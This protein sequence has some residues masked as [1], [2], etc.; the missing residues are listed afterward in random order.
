MVRV[1]V[2]VRVRIRDKGQGMGQGLGVRVRGKVVADLTKCVVVSASKFR[3]FD[4]I[5][6][7]YDRSCRR[8]VAAAQKR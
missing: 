3:H 5:C 7:R 8:S 6:R 2:R 4:F 1:R